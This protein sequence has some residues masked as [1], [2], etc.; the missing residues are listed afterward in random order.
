MA[1][2]QNLIRVDI[3]K[4]TMTNKELKIK[5]NRMLN[6]NIRRGMHCNKYLVVNRFLK[7]NKNYK[8]D[9]QTI[10]HEKDPNINMTEFQ[11]LYK[12]NKVIK[13]NESVDIYE[14]V[15]CN[16]IPLESEGYTEE[17]KVNWYNDLA[18]NP[19]TARYYKTIRNT[20]GDPDGC[21]WTCAG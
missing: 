11:L 2:V 15:F 13:S 4:H 8:I 20:G 5:K 17:E 1:N 21:C 14:F 9:K 16:V 7:Y 12:G 6:N 10:P 18:T 3:T 19:S